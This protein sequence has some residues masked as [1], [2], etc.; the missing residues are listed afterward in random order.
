VVK[1]ISLQDYHN[2]L[3]AFCD[4]DPMIR[5]AAI[6]RAGS[7]LDRNA[8]LRKTLRDLLRDGTPLVARYAA[9]TLAQAGDPAGLEAL[10]AAICSAN[11]NERTELDGCLR[12]CVQFP[13]AVLLNER[14][15]VETI[16]AVRDEAWRTFLHSILLLTSDRFY[17]IVEHDDAFRT[18]L[19]DSLSSTGPVAGL[20]LRPGTMLDVGRILSVP[21]GKQPGFLCCPT[22]HLFVKFREE[23][24]LNRQY[25]DAAQQ[26]L[27][28][29]RSADKGLETDHLYILEDAERDWN[30]LT[31][32]VVAGTKMDG[33]LRPAVVIGKS[34]N[35]P[36]AEV[37]CSSGRQFLEAYRAQRAFIGQFALVEEETELGK[38]Q[39]HFVPDIALS[40]QLVHAIVSA[41]A[42]VNGSVVGYVRTVQAVRH[43][44]TGLTRVTVQLADG[45]EISALAP[46]PE[47]N[48]CA[49]MKTCHVCQ[50]RGEWPCQGAFH[51]FRCDGTCR[52]QDGRNCLLCQQRGF[53]FGC[54]GKGQVDCPA[55]DGS[56]TAPGAR[57]NRNL[58]S[59]LWAA[60]MTC[61][62]LQ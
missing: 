31:T 10:L 9:V 29:A 42:T 39:C 23:S 59:A 19:L 56:G 52:L 2:R 25:L 57:V 7:K 50:G 27:F 14:M 46:S 60:M 18:Q 51:C 21:L 8:T 62:G 49:L 43:Q 20:R 16:P 47:E 36:R 15:Y 32:E 17:E 53:L 28:V 48:E 1:A 34:D 54:E 11:E 22:R 37:L 13:F 12:N 30:S 58:P 33:A 24:V 40:R 26:A 3:E 5:I 44:K 38:A 55:C 35:P 4:P 45:S 41:Y 6:H 61:F